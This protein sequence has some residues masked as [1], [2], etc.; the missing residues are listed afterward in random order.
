MK[1]YI[2]LL[3]SILLLF[4]MI[5][6]SSSASIKEKGKVPLITFKTEEIT[7]VKLLDVKENNKL[8]TEIN[9][10]VFIGQMIKSIKKGTSK[11]ISL[12]KQTRDS[13]NTKMELLS[14]K[15]KETLLIWVNDND[16]IT[17]A[18]DTNQN[19]TQGVQ[20]Q[21]D[22]QTPMIVVNFLKQ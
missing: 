14:N 15:S 4:C 20:I 8:K 16:T 1:T 6:C 9:D 21:H 13:V 22:F 17:V 10:T 19:T 3:F 2:Y 5:G 18:K 11:E 12:N 7:T